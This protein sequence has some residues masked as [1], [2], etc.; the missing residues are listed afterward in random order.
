MISLV[1]SGSWFPFPVKAS[2]TTSLGCGTRG[3]VQLRHHLN[4]MMGDQGLPGEL[5]KRFPTWIHVSVPYQYRIE[6]LVNWCQLYVSFSPK[7]DRTLTSAKH[8]DG[9]E[10]TQQITYLVTYCDILVTYGDFWPAFIL[11]STKLPRPKRRP[12]DLDAKT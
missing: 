12:F 7:F 6:F 9:K 2:Q 1:P 10:K 4:G 8:I 3:A 5:Q 11:L